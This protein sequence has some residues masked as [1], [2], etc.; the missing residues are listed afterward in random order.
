MLMYGKLMLSFYAC[1]CC[2]L[3]FS[4]VFCMQFPYKTHVNGLPTVTVAE[5]LLNVTNN[6]ENYLALNVCCT[7]WLENILYT[8]CMYACMCVCMTRM[9]ICIY[10]YVRM[11]VR[12]C[13]VVPWRMAT[14]F[15][16]W[17]PTNSVLPVYISET[18]FFHRSQYA[19]FASFFWPPTFPSFS[20]S[21]NF[22][23]NLLLSI[24][25]RCPYKTNSFAQISSRIVVL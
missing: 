11:Y 9:Y 17:S 24:L 14:S 19:L 12:M 23:G 25:W 7:L 10:M 16:T 20:R 2:S 21:Q 5:D 22:L 4:T 18:T 13:A 1:K 8:K 15:D 6:T 3:Y